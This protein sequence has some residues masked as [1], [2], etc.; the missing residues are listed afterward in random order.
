MTTS[1][2]PCLIFFAGGIL[3]AVTRGVTRSV[4]LLEIPLV[5]ALNLYMMGEGAYYQIPLLNYELTLVRVDRLS[6][7]YALIG[8]GPIR[9]G[10][11]LR[12]TIRA[13]TEGGKGS[14]ATP[15]GRLRSLLSE[16][17]CQ[18]A[19]DPERSLYRA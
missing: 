6:N 10:S 9:R 12:S 18:R 11:S 15:I 13:K 3:V 4:I 7:A 1:L 16:P 17:R 14:R 8:R 2:A 5:G 19:I